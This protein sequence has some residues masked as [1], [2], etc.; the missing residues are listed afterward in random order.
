MTLAQYPEVEELVAVLLAEVRAILGEALIGMYLYGSLATGGFDHDSDVDYVVVTREE[1]TESQFAA[2]EALHHRIKT[3]KVWCADQLE[4]SYIPLDGLRNY[5]PA[6]ALFVH[7][8]RGPEEHLHRMQLDDEQISRAWWGGWVLLRQALRENGLILTGPDPKTLLEPVPAA[9]V[10]QAALLILLGWAAGLLDT[11]EQISGRGY[12][13][14]TVLTL[15]RIL[16][17]LHTSQVTSKPE[18]IRWAKAH[19]DKKWI[20]LFD[21][22]W[23]GRQNPELAAEPEDVSETLEFIRFTMERSQQLELAKKEK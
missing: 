8:D 1:L 6:R 22:A 23:L 21:R 15:C 14:Y 17:T 3:L 10:R 9:D 2:I 16:Y 20:P 13:S 18:A 5:D 19:L 11:P 12:Q 4:G 7:L